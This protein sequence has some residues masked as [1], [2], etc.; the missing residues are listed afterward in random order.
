MIPGECCLIYARLFLARRDV[1]LPIFDETVVVG[2]AAAAAAAARVI[3]FGA[4]KRSEWT[5]QKVM[6][7]H[8][9]L[10]KKKVGCAGIPCGAD[11]GGEEDLIGGLPNRCGDSRESRTGE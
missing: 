6:K 11:H 2:V 5:Y 10:F 4:A 3:A 8:A 7:K 1:A 9:Y